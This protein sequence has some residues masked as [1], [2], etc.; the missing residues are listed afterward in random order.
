MHHLHQLWLDPGFPANSPHPP[1]MHFWLLVLHLGQCN[2]CNKIPVGC[3]ALQKL[4]LTQ[5]SGQ[6][7]ATNPSPRV[8]VGGATLGGTTG[9]MRHNHIITGH[10]TPSTELWQTH[11][12]PPTKSTSISSYRATPSMPNVLIFQAV[13][14]DCVERD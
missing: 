5:E 11:A 6:Q 2:I 4:G 3:L 13:A 1:K 9:R 10:H 12:P 14:F 8:E 7:L